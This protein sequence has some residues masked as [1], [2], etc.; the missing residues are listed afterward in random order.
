MFLSK[1]LI[2]IDDFEEQWKWQILKNLQLLNDA[3]FIEDRKPLSLK[4]NSFG[5]RTGTEN[6]VVHNSSAHVARSD[7]SKTHVVICNWKKL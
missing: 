6:H 1:I 3:L 7:G 5:S 2:W 4:N